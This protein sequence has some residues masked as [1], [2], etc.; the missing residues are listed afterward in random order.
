MT[1]R[2]HLPLFLLSLLIAI[3]IKLAVSGDNQQRERNFD[4][5]VTYLT[6]DGVSVL[7]QVGEVKVRLRGKSQDMAVLSPFAVEVE[8]RLEEG[9]L[10]TINYPLE[11]SGVRVPGDFEVVSIE[12][13]QLLLEI[14]Q[15]V[16]RRLEIRADLQGEPAAGSSVLGIPQVEPKEAEIKGPESRVRVLDFVRTTPISL[17]GRAISFTVP[18]SLLSP[19]PVVQ[20]LSPTRVEVSVEMREPELSSTFEELLPR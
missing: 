18:A 14:E 10:G 16:R 4:A 9:Q 19:D 13:N 6:Q 1:G 20:I 15:E 3:G 11:P 12:P 17:D 2:L 7:G 8:V 5:K